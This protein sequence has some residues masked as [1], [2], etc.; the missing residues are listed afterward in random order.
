MDE[1]SFTS[2]PYLTTD[3]YYLRRLNLTDENEI[4]ILRSDDRINKYLDRPKAESL[5]DARKFINRIINA[6]TE[7]ESVFWVISAKN[8]SKLIGTI[9]LW[10][11]SEDKSKAEIGF[12]LLPDYHGKGIMQE[13]IPVILKYGFEKM[14]LH[15]IEGEVEPNNMKSI[16][17]MEKNGFAYHTKLENTVIFSLINNKGEK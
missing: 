1:L 11:I 9:C 15:V 5:E 14:K 2:F 17:L 3:N 8:D 10:N 16:K 4:F 12:E 6:M 13:V 7:K